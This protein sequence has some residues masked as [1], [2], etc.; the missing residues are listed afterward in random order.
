MGKTKKTLLKIVV[1]IIIFSLLCISE[2]VLHFHGV[3]LAF[4]LALIY[5]REKVVIIL[6][7]YVA[8][9][10][11]FAFSIEYLI[12]IAFIIVIIC[13]FKMIH[14]RI[15]KQ[16]I[17][18]EINLLLLL[19]EI[20]QIVFFAKGIEQLIYI[21]AGILLTQGFLY[22]CIVFLYP[23]LVR[24]LKYRLSQ[25]EEIAIL[26][27][28]SVLA[29]GLATLNPYD[30]NIYFAIASLIILIGKGLLKEKACFIAIALGIGGCV[31]NLDINIL[32]ISAIMGIV[33]L[34]FYGANKY[35]SALALAVGFL[36]SWHFLV[37]PITIKVISPVLVGCLLSLFVPQKLYNLLNKYKQIYQGKF[38]LRTVV[39][40]DREAVAIRI[41]YVAKAFEDM[42]RI[43]V[44]EQLSGT[45]EV[46]CVTNEIS[47]KVCGC[48]RNREICQIKNNGELYN[49]IISLVKKAFERGKV[50]LLDTN[51]LLSDNCIMLPNLVSTV[52]ECVYN[53]KE[54]QI[55]LQGLMEGR[56]MLISQMGGVSELMQ[57]L[58]SEVN[59]GFIYDTNLETKIIDTLSY[60]NVVASDVV[61]YGKD[62]NI[63]EVNLVVRE[64]DSEKNIIPKIISE[65]INRKM[66][67]NSCIYEINNMVSLNLAPAPKFTVCYG[68]CGEAKEDKCGDTRQAVR[69]AK[70]KVMFVLSDGMGSGQNAYETANNIIILIES[71]YKAGYQHSVVLTMVSKLLAF[72]LK[73][74]FSALDILILDTQTGDID[75]IKQG[76]RESYL[77]SK[78]G[79]EVISGNSLPIGIVA[80]CEPNIQTRKMNKEEIFIMIS[81]GVADFINEDNVSEL[82]SETGY[83]NPQF[84][85]NKIVENA[86]RLG[87][88]NLDDMTCMAI[89]IK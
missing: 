21:I 62:K 49:C 47:M 82:L 67:I 38:A 7:I 16:F 72:R 75:I 33:C 3:G 48:C 85:A 18:L 13:I 89:K 31:P 19:C 34:I 51:V 76:G 32:A 57:K 84:V 9:S 66:I 73:E 2:S 55:K 17:M 14:Y 79:C 65:I 28:M 44:S 86:Q 30:I 46:D 39:N 70:D 68:E 8:S 78:N 23:I 5:C 69:I 54:A 81:D 50:T 53:K 60:S 22:I 11:I 80:D 10:L 56:E 15:Q 25:K 6:P 12:C 52:N 24:G 1:Y 40:R 27:G 64:K 42:R 59:K 61:V 41:N 77:Y 74:D 36:I 35:F 26:I 29:I 71:F 87:G 45:N 43:L 63:E 83:D 37:T 4:L 20:P 88:N 58:A